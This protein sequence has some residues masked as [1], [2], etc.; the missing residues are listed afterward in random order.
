MLGTRPCALQEA[1][2]RWRARFLE[3]CGAAGIA[4]SV[5]SQVQAS[6]VQLNEY[7][8]IACNRM[9]DEAATNIVRH[10]QAGSARLTVRYG[11]GRLDLIAEDDG[12]AEPDTLPQGRGLRGLA[13]RCRG[14]GGTLELS[15]SNMR[16]L[17]VHQSF[18]L[19]TLE[20][21]AAPAAMAPE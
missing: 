5:R 10:S 18:A 1:V 14:L 16:G 15:T 21:D 19:E 13:E 2:A 7:Q 9:V 3:A 12:H 17:C 6:E 8:M 20:S 4:A 11:Q